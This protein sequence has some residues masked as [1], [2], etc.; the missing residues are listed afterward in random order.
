VDDEA[1]FS[2]VESATD[3]GDRSVRCSSGAVSRRPS[4]ANSPSTENPVAAW[5]IIASAL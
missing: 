4:L 5:F 2:P 3:M 1:A